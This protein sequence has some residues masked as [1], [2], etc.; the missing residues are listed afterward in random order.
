MTIMSCLE[1]QTVRSITFKVQAGVLKLH[2]YKNLSFIKQDIFYVLYIIHVATLNEYA[3][4]QCVTATTDAF[5]IVDQMIANGQHE[6]LAIDFKACTLLN[7]K[8]DIFQVCALSCVIFMGLCLIHMSTRLYA[9][10]HRRSE[11]QF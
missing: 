7:T 10:A 5:K 1:Q 11:K 6:D 9:I 4:F 8:D 3:M 2:S